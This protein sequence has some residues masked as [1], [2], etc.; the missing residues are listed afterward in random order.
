MILVTTPVDAPPPPLSVA[1]GSL[2]YADRCAIRVAY[3]TLEGSDDM[4]W[5]TGFLAHYFVASAPNTETDKVLLQTPG[6]DEG[7]AAASEDGP[8]DAH[9]AEPGLAAGRALPRLTLCGNQIS[10][11]PCHRRDVLP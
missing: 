5:G 7:F 9:I 4:D 2:A 6:T 8:E 1:C 11:A 10:G 3:S